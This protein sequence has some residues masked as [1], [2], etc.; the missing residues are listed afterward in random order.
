MTVGSMGIKFLL[1]AIWIAAWLDSLA[2]ADSFYG[3]VRIPLKK[4]PLDLYTINAARIIAAGTSPVRGIENTNTSFMKTKEN[5]VYLKNYLDTQYYGEIGIGS[6]PQSFT[7]IFD[8]GSSNLWVPSSKCLLSV[9]PT[10][11]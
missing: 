11:T 7:V 2:P 8:T 9:S 10:R 1:L 6:P 3:L 4:R 5:I